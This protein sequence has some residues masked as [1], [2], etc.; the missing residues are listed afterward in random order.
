MPEYDY[1]VKVVLIGDNAEGKAYLA[2]KFCKNFFATD[3]KFTIGI[4]FY[5]KTLIALGKTMKLQLWELGNDE[6]FK[7]H[8]PFYYRGALGAIIISD[9]SNFDFQYNL[10]E[11]IQMV[12][13]QI[14]DIPIMLFTFNADSEEFQAVFGMKTMMTANN[15]RSL[16]IS[17]I[18]SKPIQNPEEIFNKIG[19][20]IIKR[21]NSTP[22]PRATK[23]PHSSN[24]RSRRA[25]FIINKYLKLRLESG[26]TNLYVGEKLFRQCKY[27]LLNIP[28]SRI[29][30]YDEIESIDE[31][32]EKLDHSMERGKQKKY[33]LSPDIEFWGHCS[34]LQVWYENNY[35]TRILHSNLSFPLLE[36]LVKVGDPLAKKVF[37]EEI[38]LRF[39][40]GYPS[41]VQHIV[42]QD[43]LKYFNKEELDTLLDDQNFIKNLPRW[44]NDI[45]DI[46]KWLSKKIKSKINYLECPLSY[47]L[48]FHSNG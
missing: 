20:Y 24:L 46:P 13:E 6:I 38:A 11:N 29:N 26:H 3:Y 22:P 4:S 18:S 34:N 21:L 2:S 40:N 17:N 41:V 10:E 31:A 5:S 8:V 12:I 42:N 27:L 9:R 35:D 7:P 30:N 14:G 48:H 43:Y 44:F 36:A 37:K 33:H 1:N 25:E 39:A 32:A 19:N 47:N 28:V 16:T 15:Y 23:P 45:K